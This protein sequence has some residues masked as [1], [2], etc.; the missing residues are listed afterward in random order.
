MS[1]LTD[2]F[3]KIKDSLHYGPAVEPFHRAVIAA[4]E[5]LQKAHDALVEEKNKLK[6]DVEALKE[7]IESLFP[8]MPASAPDYRNQTAMQSALNS[9]NPAEPAEVVSSAVSSPAQP[10]PVPAGPDAAL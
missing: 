3:E 8:T 7:R 9:Q 4:H 1:K 5:E 6:A 2:I 10:E